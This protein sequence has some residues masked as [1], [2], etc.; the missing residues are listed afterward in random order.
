M[1]K[2]LTFLIALASL[3]TGAPASAGCMALLGVGT[4]N[5]GAP[6]RAVLKRPLS[7]PAMA[8]PTQQSQQHSSAAA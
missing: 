5:C 8:T 2:L 6:L 4:A 3:A 7:W 1:R